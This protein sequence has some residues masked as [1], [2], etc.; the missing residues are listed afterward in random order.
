MLSVSQTREFIDYGKQN[1]LCV[2]E[3][4]RKVND[5]YAFILIGIVACPCNQHLG[6]SVPNGQQR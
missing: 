5:L 1:V 3:P 4:V 6:I 2:C